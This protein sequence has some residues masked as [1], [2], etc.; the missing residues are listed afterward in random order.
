MD[1][2]LQFLCDFWVLVVVMAVLG[3]E[4]PFNTNN[5]PTIDCFELFYHEKISKGLVML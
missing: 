1:L 2:W 3:L 5:I 4:C